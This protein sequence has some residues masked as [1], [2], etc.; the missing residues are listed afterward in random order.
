MQSFNVMGDATYYT[1][2]VNLVDIFC[3]EYLKDFTKIH[4]IDLDAATGFKGSS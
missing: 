1:Y 3:V 4:L 2:A